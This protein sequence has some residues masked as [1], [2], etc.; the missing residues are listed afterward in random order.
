[1]GTTRNKVWT[2]ESLCCFCVGFTR[3]LQDT[4]LICYLPLSASTYLSMP[5]VSSAIL[6]IPVV[7][8]QSDSRSV[9]VLHSMISIIIDT[10]L[11]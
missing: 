11:S 6:Y 5:S 4:S 8:L 2:K 9:D 10:D 3:C 1:M 7:L